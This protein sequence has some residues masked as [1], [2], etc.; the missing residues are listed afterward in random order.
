MSRQ[1]QH[2]EIA[3]NRRSRPQPIK[4]AAASAARRTSKSPTRLSQCF[5]PSPSRSEPSAYAT[6]TD[7]IND[8]KRR[9]LRA[10]LSVGVVNVPS[11]CRPVFEGM[12]SESMALAEKLLAEDRRLHAIEVSDE[13]LSYE[14]CLEIGEALGDVKTEEWTKRAEEEI[15]KLEIEVYDRQAACEHKCLVCLQQYESSD[16]L[17]SLPCGHSFHICCV[18][19][20]LMR[21]NACP[22]CRKPI[23]ESH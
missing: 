15:N 10:Q 19:Q 22:C 18:D 11:I 4:L 13:E 8:E 7:P 5:A 14:A 12:D 17:R 23:D 2:M 6:R 16:V 20:W 1:Q 9:K 21:T 3:S